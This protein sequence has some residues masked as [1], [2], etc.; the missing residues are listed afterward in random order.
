LDF[1]LYFICL[2]VLAYLIL[3]ASYGAQRA[4]ALCRLLMTEPIRASAL[5]DSQREKL[6]IMKPVG[7]IYTTREGQTRRIAEHLSADFRERGFCVEIVNVADRL[8]EIDLNSFSF[9]LLAASVHAGKHEREMIRFVKTHR[10]QLEQMPAAFISVTL[11]E[12]G[13]ERAGATP[14]ERAPFAADV[15]KVIDAFFEQ[16]GW[17]PKHVMPVAGALLYTKYSF[18]FRFVMKRIARKAGAAT[19]TSRDYEYTDWLAL[20]RFVHELIPEVAAQHC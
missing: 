10:G 20:E 19:D 14:A 3:F 13:A 7:I 17:H 2:C 4:A 9:A 15:K 12:A 6:M 1:L 16:T 8:E 5:T 18:P 11:S